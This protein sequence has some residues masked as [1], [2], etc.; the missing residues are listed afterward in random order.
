MSKFDIYETIT[1]KFIESLERGSIPWKRPY[2]GMVEPYN[3][4]SKKA[5]NGINKM[6]L[7]MLPYSHKEYMTFKQADKLG[8][9][10]K[11]GEKSTM[12]VFWK[13][14]ESKDK[15]TGKIKSFPM[16]RYYRVFNIEQVEGIEIPVHDDTD[17]VINPI[18]AADKVIKDSNT[19]NLQFI[20]STPCYVPSTD[21]IRLPQE[22]QFNSSEEMY[23]TIFHEMVHSTGHKDR[24]NR[25]ELVDT[26]TFR[27]MSYSK[28]ELTAEI[29]SSFLNHSCGFGDHE[30]E[31]SEAYIK[32]WI[33]KLTDHKKMIIQ[34]SGKAQHAVN[35]ILNV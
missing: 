22:G 12:I 32:S 2:T 4:V 28:E 10:V 6:I 5:Y 7:G 11:K 19:P 27:S 1:E 30:Q 20:G 26:H 24:L 35:F 25:K 34:A 33:R 31:N 21:E 15:D 13:F 8:G 29:G 16:L 23:S 9:K 18:V 3:M 14:F 17:K